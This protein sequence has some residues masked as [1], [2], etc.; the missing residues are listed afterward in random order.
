MAF[1]DDGKT[2]EVTGHG[3]VELIDVIDPAVFSEITKFYD[4]LE[5]RD[6]IIKSKVRSHRW[7][8][9]ECGPWR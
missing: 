2:I 7:P 6:G 4:K 1:S 8:G 3:S 5:L 9:V